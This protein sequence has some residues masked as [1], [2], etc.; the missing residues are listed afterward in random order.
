MRATT[1]IIYPDKGPKIVIEG[2]LKKHKPSYDSEIDKSMHQ[3][4]LDGYYKSECEGK[5]RPTDI[6]KSKAY[7]KRVHEEALA[8]G[9]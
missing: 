6:I 2:G 9:E 1:T 5:L 7:M 4:V 3:R 8:R